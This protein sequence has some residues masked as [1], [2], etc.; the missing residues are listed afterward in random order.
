VILC[1]IVDRDIVF[2]GAHQFVLSTDHAVGVVVVKCVISV[3]IMV[4]YACVDVRKVG[5]VE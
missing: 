5:G 3:V 2:R 4:I 1:I